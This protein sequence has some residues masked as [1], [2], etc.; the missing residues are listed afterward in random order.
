MSFVPIRIHSRACH[1][2]DATVG[3]IRRYGHDYVDFRLSN[4]VLKAVGWSRATRV[5]AFADMS[6]C[7][8][9]LTTCGS[10]DSTG[11]S[12][13]HQGGRTLSVRWPRMGPFLHL[14]PALDRRQTLPVIRAE[15]GQ[16]VFDCSKLPNTT[17]K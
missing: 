2:A 16:V 1:Q 3:V 5:S 4:S 11:R 17:A 9:M 8:L 10:T 12:L 15:A 14:V 13:S 6:A 7:Q